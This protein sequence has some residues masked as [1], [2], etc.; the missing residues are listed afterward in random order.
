MATESVSQRPIPPVVVAVDAS[1]RCAE[2]LET[3]ALLAAREGADLEVVFVEDADLLRLADLPVTHEIDR[4]SGAIRDIDSRRML[5]AL[6]HETRRL[7]QAVARIEHERAV[8]SRLRIARGRKLAE[9]LSAAA[10][11]DVTFVHAAAHA[12][13]D[14]NPA[15]GSRPTRGPR[16]KSVWSLFEGGAQSARALDTAAKLAKALGCNLI[17]LIP[18]PAAGEAESLAREAGARIGDVEVRFVDISANRAALESPSLQLR[19]ARLLVLARQSP[20]LE[21]AQA[22]GYLESLPV[23]LVLVA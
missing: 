20:S 13:S 7:R 8:R 23:P 2:T 19:R 12:L 3:A 11:V 14:G 10:G 1:E 9:A 6:G 4:V 15:S 5:R 21:D 16:G 22:R 18:R 17:V